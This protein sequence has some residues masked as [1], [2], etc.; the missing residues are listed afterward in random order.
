MR[1]ALRVAV[2]ARSVFPLA[3]PR[4]PRAARLRPRA[5]PR[6][7]GRRNDAHHAPAEDASGR[8]FDPPAASRSGRSPIGRFRWR[9]QT[10]HDGDRSE[11]GV[12]AVW[13]ARRATGLGARPR[14]QDRHRPRARRER[15]RICPAAR[16]EHR[17]ARAQPA[18]PRG[19]RRHQSRAGRGS[20]ARGICRCDAPSS[21]A[22]RRPI[23]S[24]RPTARSSPS[25]ANISTCP[26]NACAS[27]RTRSISH[28]LDRLATPRRR[29][30][31]APRGRHRARRCSA[32]ERG[33]ARGEQGLPP[34]GRRARRALPRTA[35]VCPR[36][37]GAGS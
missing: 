29:R 12:S 23:G 2:V 15:A 17:A 20:S 31:R 36:G 1:P 19:I 11:H 5:L 26:R 32:A 37:D 7:R 34:S 25:S 18:G 3:W 4:R 24:S 10:R 16:D 13:V 28:W 21:S 8:G 22:R 27:F 33:T 35:D 30:A 14:R 9:G 6:R